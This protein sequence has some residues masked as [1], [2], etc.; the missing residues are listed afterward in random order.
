MTLEPQFTWCDLST[1]RPEVTQPFYNAV[2]GWDYEGPAAGYGLDSVYAHFNQEPVAA[3]YPMPHRFRDMGMPSFWMS[4]ITVSE[5]GDI[6]NQAPEAGGRV[7]LSDENFALIRDP[8]G[9][10]FT[11]TL[12][13]GTWPAP[14]HVAPGRRAGHS[15]FCSDFSAVE[16]FYRRLFGW[17]FER[18]SKGSA[19]IR[20][21]DGVKVASALQLPEH[22]RGKE[23]YWAV[24]FAVD[25]IP[26]AVDRAR[27][28]G[29]QDIT[30]VELPEGASALIHDPDN[31]AFFVT[32]AA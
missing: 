16:G 30:P 31:A 17:E 8:L 1:F 3:L 26:D 32:E 7:E 28:A 19:T 14:K 27:Q 4:Y 13:E 9:A 2:L 22:L 5:F 23:Q 12:V 11:V 15:Y 24:R 18:H 25:S 20:T 29:A 10:G 21:R 6:T